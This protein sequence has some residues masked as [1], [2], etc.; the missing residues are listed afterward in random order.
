MSLYIQATIAVLFL[1]QLTLARLIFPESKP[2]LIEPSSSDKVPQIDP[3]IIG[4]EAAPFETTRHQVSLRLKTVE[5]QLGFGEGHICGGSLI[6]QNFVVTAAHCVYRYVLEPRPGYVLRDASEFQVVLGNLQRLQKTDK[7]VIATV[8]K[9][10]P[11]ELYCPD[12]LLNDIALLELS[13]PVSAS[14]PSNKTAEDP[15]SV[16]RLASQSPSGFKV[17]T[18]TGWGYTNKTESIIPDTLN[19]VNLQLIE[20]DNCIVSYGTSIGP[21]MLCAGGAYGQKSAC[22]GDSGGPLVCDGVLQGIVS[23]GPSNCLSVC[24]PNVYTRVTYYRPWIEYTLG[25][26]AKN[27]PS[28]AKHIFGSIQLI[29]TLGFLIVIAQIKN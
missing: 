22:N 16:I 21:G 12:Q 8:K 15:I 17:C 3:K 6:L 7:T 29:L 13:Q 20:Q 11:H 9:I 18:V 1:S 19:T 27:L 24:S 14:F 4:G 10:I 2:A 25:S 28:S 23:W 26:A 5:E